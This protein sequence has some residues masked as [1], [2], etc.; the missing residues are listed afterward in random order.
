[1][2]HSVRLIIS[3]K[4]ILTTGEPIVKM[5][6]LNKEFLMD[7]RNGKY[8]HEYLMNYLDQKM[9]ELEELY[10]NCTVIP[11]YVD[12][13]KINDLYLELIGM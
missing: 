11:K 10:N 9:K 2:M 4:S 1:M 12:E 5:E 6:G 3:T 13:H 8:T 7:I